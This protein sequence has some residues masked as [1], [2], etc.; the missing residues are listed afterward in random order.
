MAG[1]IPTRARRAGTWCAALLLLALAA[2]SND[3]PVQPGPMPQPQPQPAN[4]A[5]VIESIAV[6]AQRVEADTEVTVTATVRDVET[7]IDQLRFTWSAD[8]GTFSGSGPSVRWRLPKGGSTPVEHTLRLSV[9]ETYGPSGSLQH[10]VT[11]TSPA[12]RVHDSPKEL[13]ELALRFLQNFANS[14]VPADVAIRDFSD[15]CGGKRAERD[16]IEGNR[17][18]FDVLSSR[19]SLS[20]ARVTSPWARGEMTVRCEFSSR[21]KNCPPGSPSSCRVGA[22]E[23]VEGNCNMTAVY[24]QQRWFL[25]DS[26]FDGRLVPIMQ[27]FFGRER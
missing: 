15:S 23:N 20:H 19:L 8:A 14:S 17:R 2:C 22:I 4:Q 7:A 24:E 27:G 26:T 3:S 25:C 10:T 12:I 21:R 11:G 16:D 13:G 5:P 6:S 9:V 18:D 1:A